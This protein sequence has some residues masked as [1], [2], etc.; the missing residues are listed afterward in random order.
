MVSYVMESRKGRRSLVALLVALAIATVGLYLATSA[1]ATKPAKATTF[2]NSFAHGP[3][4]D[5]DADGNLIVRFHGRVQC[6][7]PD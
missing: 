2:C 7:R 1:T 6:E 3:I 5:R 4:Q